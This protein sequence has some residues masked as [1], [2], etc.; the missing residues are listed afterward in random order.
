[1]CAIFAEV[2]PDVS[3]LAGMG[4]LLAGLAALVLQVWNTRRSNKIQDE[5]RSLAEAWRNLDAVKKDYTEVRAELTGV[6][7]ENSRCRSEHAVA[8]E[9]ISFL[10]EWLEHNGVKV[11][12]RRP[13]GMSDSDLAHHPLPPSAKKKGG[14]S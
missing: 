9:R 13:P 6:R 12:R 3:G 2:L 10:E 4:G 8:I 5:D 7:E 14:E 11:P 1:M